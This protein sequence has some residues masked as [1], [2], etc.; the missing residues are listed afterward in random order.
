MV[1]KN[2]FQGPVNINGIKKFSWKCISNIHDHLSSLN[3][4]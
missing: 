1:R 3:I 4:P 2:C